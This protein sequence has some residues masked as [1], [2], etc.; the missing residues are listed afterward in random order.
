MKG[1]N[2][3]NTSIWFRENGDFRTIGNPEAI[4][5]M[6]ELDEANNLLKYVLVG[7]GGFAQKIKILKPN[8]TI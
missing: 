5:K 6:K 1:G 8:P 2:G 4:Y 7:E 3:K